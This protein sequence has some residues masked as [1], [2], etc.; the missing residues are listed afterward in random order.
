M[1]HEIKNPLTPIKLSAERLLKKWEQ[2]D[3]DFDRIFEPSTKTIVKQVDSLKRFVDDV[4]RLG[5]MP[6]IKRRRQILPL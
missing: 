5:K 1:A 3:K 2:K 4:S 6:E